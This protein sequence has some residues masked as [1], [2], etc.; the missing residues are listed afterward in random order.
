L[1]KA[2]L[3]RAL[4]AR[5]AA[6]DP[7]V[8]AEW[9]GRICRALVDW[10]DGVR[11][12]SIAVY[13]PIKGEP[14]LAAACGQLAA[15]GVQ[16]ALPVVLERDAPLSFAHWTFGEEMVRDAMGVAIPSHLRLVERPAAIVIPCL[17]FNGANYRLGYGGGYYD[18]TL[19]S[20]PRPRTVGVA[21]AFGKV[22]FASAAHDVALDLIVTEG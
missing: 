20:V 9:D 1:D 11:V 21:Y 19:A 4:A 18:R 22:E 7:A 12:P 8:K 13:W 3:R 16:L 10:W 5:R 17:G 15:R 2:A 6:L 14:D